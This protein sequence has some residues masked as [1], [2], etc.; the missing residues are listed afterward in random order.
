[1]P[2][3][4]RDFDPLTGSQGDALVIHNHRR[5]T[6]Q[7]IKEL[8]RMVMKMFDFKFA[9]RHALLN[10]A[11]SVAFEQMPAVTTITPIVMFCVVERNRFHHASS[12]F[13]HRFCWRWNISELNVVKLFIESSVCQQGFVRAFFDDAAFV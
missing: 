9:G 11:E 13:N 2:S 1:M 7:N 12:I 10:D 8:P 5:F 3:A 6:A 4:R